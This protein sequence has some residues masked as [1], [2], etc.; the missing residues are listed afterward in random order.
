VGQPVKAPHKIPSLLYQTV[1]KGVEV[2]AD[3]ELC[4]GL[5]P[6]QPKIEEYT[7]CEMSATRATKENRSTNTTPKKHHGVK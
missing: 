4:L 3:S 5:S 6:Y 2:L 7:I 1:K